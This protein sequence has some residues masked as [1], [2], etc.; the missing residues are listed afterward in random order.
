MSQNTAALGLHH[1]IDKSPSTLLAIVL[2]FTLPEARVDVI[3]RR[4]SKMY[5]INMVG[6]SSSR[7]VGVTYGTEFEVHQR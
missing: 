5:F 6:D 2:F 7:V 4:E 1:F 3:H